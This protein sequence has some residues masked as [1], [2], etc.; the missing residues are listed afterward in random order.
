MKVLILG[1]SKCG[2]TTAGDI[3]ASA[4]NQG[5]KS[6][7]TSDVLIGLL[8]ADLGVT[9]DEIRSDKDRLR[10]KL[11]SKGRELQEQDP[12]SIVN[13]A[14]AMAMVGNDCVVT[15]VR[16]RDEI[17]ALRANRTFDLI[18]WIDRCCCEAGP[19]DHIDPR[20]ADIIISN[21]GTISELEQQLLTIL[22]MRRG[23]DT[24]NFA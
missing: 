14:V 2:K 8:A 18:I 11:W 15:G 23:M 24:W 21:S 6:V 13:H 22:V 4:L 12:L 17:D 3:V 5:A 19:T 9:S 7:S 20:D 1:Y 16:N 10:G